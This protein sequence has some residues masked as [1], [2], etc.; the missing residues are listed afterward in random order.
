M[1]AA[2]PRQPRLLLRAGRSTIAL[3]ALV[4]ALNVAIGFELAR[5]QA[6]V[7]LLLACLPLLAVVLGWL[8]GGHRDVLA[9]A[10]LG[11]AMMGGSFNGPLP[12]TGGTAV[13]PADLLLVLALVSAIAS[14]LTQPA[15]ERP[16]WQRT[17]I[18]GWPLALLALAIALAIVRGHLHYGTKYLSEPAR[19]L[20]Y[21]GIAA[22]LAGL[23]PQRAYRG[24]VWVFYTAIVV[25]SLL[26][27]YHL[28]NG[29]SQTSA[30][31]ASL[32]TGGTRAL[33]LTT[34]M[35]LSAGLILCLLN[36][37]RD[38]TAR[39]H[40]LHLG[41]A[42]LATFGIVV[43]LS[44]T[45]F[46]AA[47]LLVP[48]LLIALR[49]MRRSLLGFLPLLVPVAILGV[50]LA[51]QVSPQLGSTVA[52]RLSGTPTSDPSL[53]T[54]QR[55]WHATLQGLGQDPL[56][57]FGFGRPVQY[58]GIDQVVVTISGDPE[59]SY[60]W[61]LASG[62][63]FALTALLFLIVGF[64]ADGIRRAVRAEGDARRLVIFCMA[65]V[66]VVLVNTLTFPLLSSAPDL[67]ALWVALLLPGL[68]RPAS[69]RARTS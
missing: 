9:F 4:T 58:T 47:A 32:S 31:A 65:F 56:I 35:Y 42:G 43:S 2:A 20:L 66:F 23:S 12:G 68:V 39:R 49:R 10:A 61:L 63:A 3:A 44:R 57:G 33:S 59:N 69:A 24:I 46:V 11:L 7:A 18:V 25:Q 6:K 26:G 34:G 51:L 45:S 15:Q 50:L 22:A 36:L 53:V 27:L 40:A 19:L 14:R 52:K 60:I 41:F 16:G 37:D 1:S 29:T 67:L 13:Y 54:R 55:E 64:F 48:V 5:G 8:A 38:D 62:G 28:A 21:A 30:A 17:F